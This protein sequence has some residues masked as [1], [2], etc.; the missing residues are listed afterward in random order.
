MLKKFADVNRWTVFDRMGKDAPFP[1]DSANSG[2]QKSLD[3]TGGVARQF[4]GDSDAIRAGVMV[5]RDTPKLSRRA[6]SAFASRS[7]A[8]LVG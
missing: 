4:V 3:F 1:L 2:I 5:D 7:A 6:V 8:V